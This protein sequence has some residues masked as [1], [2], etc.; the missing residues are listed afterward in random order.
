MRI[1]HSGNGDIV[2]RFEIPHKLYGREAEIEILN[3]GFEKAAKGHCG[4]LLVSGYSGIGKSSL[5][6]EIRK[7]IIGKKG[8][9]ISG[10]YNQFERNIP[11]YGITQAFQGIDKT[12]T[13][14]T[15]I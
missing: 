2:D 13:C 6:H 3:D 15:T 9:F 1:H 5:I 7:P 11:Y 14:A 12:V 4:I 8:Y 10:K